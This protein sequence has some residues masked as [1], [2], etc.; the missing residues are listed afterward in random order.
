MI[1]L[2]VPSIDEADYEAIR[3]VLETG[4]L[5]QGQHVATFEQSI[6]DYI[7]VDHA[8]AVSNCTAALHMALLALDVRPND[9]VIVT[10]YSWLSTANVIELCGAQP[11]FVDINAGTFNMDVDHLRATL[12]RLMATTDT[13]RRVKAIIPVH[14]FG[15]VADMPAITAIAEHYDLPVIED[16]AC[17]LGAS[18]HGQ[19]AGTWGVG[20][21]SFHPRKAITTGEGGIITTHD[22]ELANRLRALRNH[23]IDPVAGKIDFIM[24]GFNYRLTEFQAA[25]GVTQMVKLDRIITA[26]R[27]RARIYDDLLANTPY[28]APYTSEGG[29]P[30]YQSYVALIPEDADRQAI[31]D[32]LLKNDIQSTIG[33]YHMPMTTYFRTRYGYQAGDFPVAD[34]VFARSLTLPLHEFLTE[35]E[36]QQVVEHLCH[37]LGNM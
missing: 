13:A 33:T 8:V 29:E 21:F 11:I 14:T 30:V 34:N 27:E 6:A 2:T 19:Q 23:G 10:A 18:L 7:G 12:T 31:I 32:F 9:L 26:R 1:R 4:F 3:Q 36:Q 22:E 25:M 37:A 5:V 24:P 28:E 15:Q 17:A 16:A 20:C 35:D